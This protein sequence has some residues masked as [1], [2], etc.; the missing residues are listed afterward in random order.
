[1]PF[2]RPWILSVSDHGHAHTSTVP[3]EIVLGAKS[4]RLPADTQADPKITYSSVSCRNTPAHRAFC[5]NL[6]ALRTPKETISGCCRAL[7][8]VQRITSAPVPG[9]T[10][11]GLGLRC[12]NVK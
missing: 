10:A 4:P 2:C 11:P 5:N 6:G 3:P 7:L 8:Q 9:G 12:E 1:M